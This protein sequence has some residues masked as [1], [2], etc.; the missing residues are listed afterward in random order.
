MRTL[1]LAKKWLQLIYAIFFTCTSCLQYCVFIHLIIFTLHTYK[2][3][4]VFRFHVFGVGRRSIGFSIRVEVKTDSKTSVSY[5]WIHVQILS[6]NEFY[7][8]CL[9][10]LHF[11]TFKWSHRKYTSELIWS[12]FG[13]KS[14]WVRTTGLRYLMINSWGWIWLGIM[15]DILAFQHWMTSFWLRQDRCLFTSNKFLVFDF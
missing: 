15:L 3:S 13:R 9:P 5:I 12:S 14:L 2:I 1:E 11:C 4:L 7:L 8:L 6:L 10:I